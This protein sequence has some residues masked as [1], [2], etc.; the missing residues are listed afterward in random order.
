MSTNDEVHKL[1]EEGGGQ[2][3]WL[4]APLLKP[5]ASPFPLSSHLFWKDSSPH[6]NP[7]VQEAARLVRE[8]GHR[9]EERFGVSPWIAFQTLFFSSLERQVSL[10][11][12]TRRLLDVMS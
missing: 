3:A 1:W 10:L 12:L 6:N 5:F 8:R 9:I 11:H 2:A 7:E 4:Q